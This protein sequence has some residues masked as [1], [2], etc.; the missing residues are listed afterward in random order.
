[1]DRTPT[2]YTEL[3]DSIVHGLRMQGWAKI[4]AENEADARI[5]RLRDKE[6]SDGSSRAEA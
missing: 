2:D 4:E 5:E 1:M 6:M 3:R